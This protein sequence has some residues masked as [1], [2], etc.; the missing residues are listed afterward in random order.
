M[1]TDARQLTQIGD[2]VAVWIEQG[3]IHL[4]ISEKHDDP[5]ELSV[6]AAKELAHVLLRLCREIEASE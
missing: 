2:N 6:D 3:A 5:V 1:A 4:R